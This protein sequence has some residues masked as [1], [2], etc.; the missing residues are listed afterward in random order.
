M[1][2]PN[3]E[4]IVTWA[5]DALCKG[6]PQEWWYPENFNSA[7]NRKNVARAKLHCQVCPVKKQCLEYAMEHN[8]EHGV[9]GGLT[10]TER[11]NSRSYRNRVR[12]AER[13]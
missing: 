2:V 10:P 1:S 11:G 9:W 8:E 12:L 13:I 5:V 6:K 7:P 4:D 3:F